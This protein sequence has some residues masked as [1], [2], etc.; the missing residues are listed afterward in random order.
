MGS[1]CIASSPLKLSSLVLPGLP[2][3]PVLPFHVLHVSVSPTGLWVYS[4]QTGLL[5]FSGM[6]SHAQ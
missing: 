4:R 2:H 5:V 3:S 1:L 6:S